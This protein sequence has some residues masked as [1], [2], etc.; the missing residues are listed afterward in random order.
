MAR[1]PPKGFANWSEYYVYRI[2]RGEARGLSRSQA[3]GHPA[4]GEPPASKVVKDVQILG[5]SGPAVVA[6]TGTREA[7]RAGRF[8]NQVEQLRRGRITP[9]EFDRRWHEKSIG[10]NDLPTANEVLALSHRGLANFDDFY[11]KGVG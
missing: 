7:S 1:R 10:G 4:K 2:A 6:I 3:R 8:D 9:K 5:R 11:P